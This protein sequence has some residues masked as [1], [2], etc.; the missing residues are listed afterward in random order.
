VLNDTWLQLPLSER[1]IATD[2]IQVPNGAIS[3]V[4]DTDHQSMDF[5]T[6]KIIGRDIQYTQGLLAVTWDMIIASLL[7]ATRRTRPTTPLFLL[8]D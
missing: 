8:S 5:T 3:T 7:T 2:S 4:D 6:G 1:F